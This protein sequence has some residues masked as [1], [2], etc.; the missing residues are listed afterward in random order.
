MLKIELFGDF[1]QLV[2]E[3]RKRL[4]RHGIGVD[5][6]PYGMTMP[7]PFLFMKDNHS[8]LLGQTVF[9]FDGRNRLLE[10]FDPNGFGFG[11]IERDRK[12]E[13]T[14]FRTLGYSFSFTER[15]DNIA[16]HETSDI[17]DFDMLVLGCLQKMKPELLGTAALR[18]FEDHDDPRSLR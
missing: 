1:H 16:G 9:F 3:E 6:A 12:Q 5:P 10:G 18:T 11:R 4:G 13:L 14:A 17:V 15:S 8:G 7:P 2:L